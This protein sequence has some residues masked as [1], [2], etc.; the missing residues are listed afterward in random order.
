MSARLCLLTVGTG[1]ETPPAHRE[2][3]EVVRE[4][5][6]GGIEGGVISDRPVDHHQSRPVA[7]RADGDPRPVAG[8][9]TEGAASSRQSAGLAVLGL[10]DDGTLPPGSPLPTIKDLLPDMGCQSEPHTGGVALLAPWGLVDINRGRRGVI[11]PAPVPI[12][13]MT[14]AADLRPEQAYVEDIEIGRRRML[15]LVVQRRGYVVAEITA[16]SDPEDASDLQ[17]LVH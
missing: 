9:H 1:A 17:R 12:V 8:M 16:E 13:G 2:D 15:G 5:R 7:Q 4:R 10:V 6:D 3:G 11:T 14:E